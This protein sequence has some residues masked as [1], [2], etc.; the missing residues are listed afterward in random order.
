MNENCVCHIFGHPVKDAKA[1]AL[2]EEALNEKNINRYILSLNGI[3]MV[4]VSTK[5]DEST[6]LLITARPFSLCTANKDAF[7]LS[8][9]TPEYDNDTIPT[10]IYVTDSSKT[11]IDKYTVYPGQELIINKCYG[12]SVTMWVHVTEYCGIRYKSNPTD[13]GYST[14]GYL[15]SGTEPK[16]VG[17]TLSYTS[18]G[19][20][21]AY[22]IDV[23]M[24]DITTSDSSTYRYKGK[25]FVFIGDSI[26]WGYYKNG[27]STRSVNPYPAVIEKNLGCVSVNLAVSGSS[28]ASMLSTQV[29]Q[30]PDDADY[31]CVMAGINNRANTEL[32]EITDKT[33]ETWSALLYQL[34]MGIKEKVPNAKLIVF[35]PTSITNGDVVSGSFYTNVLHTI[36][37][38]QYYGIACID[39]Y[40][41][42]G[43]SYYIE[44][45]RA[46]YY[47][48][49]L[50]LNDAGYKK[51][52]DEISKMLLSVVL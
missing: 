2:S 15:G 44:S 33:G 5:N 9:T 26:T 24:V 6:T 47:S 25:K 7:I 35:T 1:R 4:D 52:G 50:H 28:F 21:I 41:R 46:M 19:Y 12:E 8:I 18:L 38:C 48:D 23:R 16:N 49:V 40:G 36:S 13:E 31:V 39:V 11:I 17:D 22:N 10:Y 34:L 20:N 37:V 51:L 3:D 42:C 45:D 27:D 30:I 29:P 43:F 32:G 14:T